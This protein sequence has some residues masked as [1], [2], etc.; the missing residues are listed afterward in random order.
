MYNVKGNEHTGQRE[1]PPEA[2]DAEDRAEEDSKPV[3]G[4]QNCLIDWILAKNRSG[5]S[6]RARPAVIY[7]DPVKFRT[8]APSPLRRYNVK[9]NDYTGQR[10]VLPK[11][12]AGVQLE[13]FTT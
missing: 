8:W 7:N 13:T 3:A 12:D 5:P 11:A 6:H 1:V 4:K 9:G 10:Q 2:D